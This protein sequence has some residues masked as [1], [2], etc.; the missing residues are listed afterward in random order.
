[1]TLSALQKFILPPLIV[2]GTVFAALTFPLAS[3]GNN[4]I[5]IK[6]QNESFF[7]GKVRDIATPYVI[8][9]TLISLG[10]GVSVAAFDGW[11]R[12]K[13]KFIS[14][15]KELSQL[16]NNLKEKEELLKELKLSEARVQMTGL[17]GFLNEDTLLEAVKNYHYPDST[18]TISQP[19][20]AQNKVII[21]EPIV[22]INHREK[23]YQ[24]QAIDIASETASMEYTVSDYP[25]DISSQKY[26]NFDVEVNPK[27]ENRIAV[28][29][30]EFEELQRQL[31]D[32]M[33]QMQIMQGTIQPEQDVEDVQEQVSE[34]FQ[35][36]YD[37]PTT[38]KAIFF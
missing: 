26:I 12:S 24:Q 4:Q 8:A 16:E 28:T 15:E 13:K 20:V 14:Y 22:N 36:F 29:V 35:V 10:T 1:M 5:G 17:Q 38:E 6:L 34:K 37:T 2:S 23:D 11:R 30:S 9:V 3:M 19:R 31:K 21:S 32:M 27:R 7:H 18:E 25:Q 33:R